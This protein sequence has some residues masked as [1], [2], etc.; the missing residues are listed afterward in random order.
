MR[1][2]AHVRFGGA[3]RGNGRFERNTP[4]PGPTP[5]SRCHDGVTGPGGSAELRSPALERG[6]MRRRRTQQRPHGVPTDSTSG[7]GQPT[8]RR[9]RLR[10]SRRRRHAPEL[11]MCGRAM[12]GAPRPAMRAT[13]SA[14]SWHLQDSEWDTSEVV[15][16]VVAVMDRDP[17][18]PR[19]RARCPASETSWSGPRAEVIEHFSF[20]AA[21][22][23]GRVRIVT[24]RRGGG[25]DGRRSAGYGGDG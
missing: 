9:A 5:T 22:G 4:R 16:A 1:G 13:V 15:V 12:V 25:R 7:T 17:S 21:R 2:N 10:R 14:A 11:S 19:P 3:G 20:V 24:C 18:N 6:S 23:R 8:A